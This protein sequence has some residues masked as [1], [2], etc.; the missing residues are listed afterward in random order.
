EPVELPV[1][2]ILNATQDAARIVREREWH[3]SRESGTWREI[4]R[5]A[6]PCVTEIA[7][8]ITA[9]PVVGG[10]GRR[11][12][13]RRF[14]RQIGRQ[15]NS[16][17]ANCGSSNQSNRE[18]HQHSPQIKLQYRIKN[19][20]GL[21]AVRQSSENPPLWQFGYFILIRY[22]PTCAGGHLQRNIR[23]L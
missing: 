20:I 21:A 3:R 5:V 17:G 23:C 12:V 1:G 10:G 9:R 18:A 22:G 2:T 14:G 15:G 19:Q 11:S 16:S 4:D 8:D 7:A 6:A 13:G